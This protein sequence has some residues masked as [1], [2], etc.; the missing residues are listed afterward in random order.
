MLEI[1]DLHV[2]YGPISAV[3]GVDLIV[4]DGQIVAL[5]GTNGAGKTTTIRAITG[6]VTPTSGRLEFDGETIDP[7][8]PGDIARRGIACV[9]EGREIFADLT[10]EQNLRLGAYSARDRKAFGD[11]LSRVHEYFPVLHERRRQVARTLS[12]GEQQMLV[13]GRALMSQPR[14]LILD[15]P[16]PG[17]APKIVGQV[18]DLIEQIC[19]EL[20]LSALVV[21]Q[22]AGYALRVA[23]SGYVMQHGKV[24]LHGPREDL[25][26]NP[27]IRDTYLGI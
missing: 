4:P 14:L 23:S 27:L 11:D 18:Y 19:R 24:L 22:D 16:S 20:R 2:G 13:I 26:D 3:R 5:M 1:S 12:G 15:E 7:R 9:P 10:V 25:I 8:R 21:E 6:L 17:L